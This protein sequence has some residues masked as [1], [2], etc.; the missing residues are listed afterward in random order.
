MS[1][2]VNGESEEGDELKVKAQQLRF[3]LTGKE[4][5]EDESQEAYDELIAYFYR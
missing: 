4:P 3:Q 1:W 5:G 2:P